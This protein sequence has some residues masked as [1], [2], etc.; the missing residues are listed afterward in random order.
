[1]PI[2]FVSLPNSDLIRNDSNA[3][4]LIEGFDDLGMLCQHLNTAYRKGEPLVSDDLYDHVF[5]KGLRQQQPDHPFLHTV[6]PEPVNPA[7][8]LV[9]HARP[10]TSTLKGY[11]QA[12]VTRYV[13]AVERAASEMGINPS[14]HGKLTK[15]EWRRETLMMTGRSSLHG[16]MG[17]KARMSHTSLSTG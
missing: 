14:A 12:D 4:D 17:S 15:W 6:E 16:A 8:R 9:Q 7:L 10:M 1:M 2:S 11:E 13:R 3:L 5:L